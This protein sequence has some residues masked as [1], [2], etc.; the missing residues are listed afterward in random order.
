MLLLNLRKQGNIF[1]EQISGHKAAFNL[2]KETLSSETLEMFK[3]RFEE[4]Y[5]IVNDSHENQLY[6]V[7]K[8]VRTLA[9]S[10]VSSTNKADSTIASTV[11]ESSRVDQSA[12]INIQSEAIII[13][14]LWKNLLWPSMVELH[15]LYQCSASL[16]ILP[17]FI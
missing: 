1:F 12:T 11:V 17:Y 14:K 16:Q 8:N 10:G 9:D 3:R 15:L 4:R 7:Y 6:R 13:H 5:D 2:V